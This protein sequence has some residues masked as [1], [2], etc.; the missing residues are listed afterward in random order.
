M[1]Q[2]GQIKPTPA[3]GNS[4]IS[5]LQLALMGRGGG[6]RTERVLAAVAAGQVLAPLAE[7]AYKRIRRRDDFTL[8]VPASDDIYPVLHEWV[9]ARMPE[10]DRKALIATTTSALEVNYSGQPA[11]PARV[12]LRYD[13]NREQS[14]SIDGHRIKVSVVREDVPAAA[15]STNADPSWMRYM[16]RITFCASTVEG[17][18]AII[19][20]IEGV[21]ADRL[22]EDLRPAVFLPS[23]WGSEWVRRGDL[24]MRTLDSTILK[25]GQLERLVA[26]LSR[27]LGAEADYDRLSQPWHRG[28]LFHGPPGTGKTSVARALA[29]HFGLP[30]YYLP[31]A[32]IEKDANLMQFVADIKPRSVLLLEDV[33]AYHATTSRKE[34]H[35]AVSIA[36]ML[37][38]LDGIWTPPGLVTILTTNHRDALDDALVRA[39]RVDVDEEFT[40]LDEEQAERMIDYFGSDLFSRDWTGCAPADL[41]EA[42]RRSELDARVEGAVPS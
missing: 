23:R 24:P 26:D 37:N 8:T 27:F 32:D 19:A 14:V 5:A 30:T 21:L 40:A 12:R 38:A 36:A 10:T 28:Y 25:S 18:G 7:R 42:V 11:E 34:K 16:E 2:A 31:L 39:G 33:D 17:R 20:M 41:I 29:N 1:M 15:R 13:G 6:R 35:D 22:S 9:L 4:A 3:S